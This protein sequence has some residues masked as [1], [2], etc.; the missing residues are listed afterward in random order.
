VL[1]ISKT[2]NL[3]INQFDAKEFRLS[4]YPLTTFYSGVDKQQTSITDPN[5]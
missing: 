3:S 5:F 4:S 1:D 2:G